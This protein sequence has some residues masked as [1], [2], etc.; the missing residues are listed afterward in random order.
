LILEELGR[1]SEF[2]A[3]ARR[4][5]QD[6]MSQHLLWI[7][8]EKGFPWAK[9]NSQCNKNFTRKKKKMKSHPIIFPFVLIIF[10]FL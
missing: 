2:T 9:E 1:D 8:G 6:F 4:R 7:F 10:C 5:V 3:K